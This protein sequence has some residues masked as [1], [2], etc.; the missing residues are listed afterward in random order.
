MGLKSG[1][2]RLGGVEFKV[3]VIGQKRSKNCIR[4]CQK[5][6]LLSSVLIAGFWPAIFGIQ[7]LAVILSSEGV[8]SGFICQSFGVY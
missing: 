6:G 1:S 5:K 2:F 7:D 3:Q 4:V 8:P